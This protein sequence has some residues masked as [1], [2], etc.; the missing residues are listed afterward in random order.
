[1]ELKYFET[2]INEIEPF[3]REQGFRK[4]GDEPADDKL[5]VCFTG[6]KKVVSVIYHENTRLVKLLMCEISDDKDAV[7]FTEKSTWLFDTDHN[8]KDAVAIG[9]DFLDVIKDEMGL[10]EKP[11]RVASS[12]E[13][14]TKGTPGEAPNIQAFAAKFLAICPEF[15][16]VYKEHVEK[17]NDFLYV[18]F[19]SET[20]VPHLKKLLW[21]K[22]KKQLVK[23]FE[24]L[25]EMYATGDNAVGS[26]ITGVIIAEA[27][28]GD[29]VYYDECAGLYMEGCKY[30][31]QRGRSMTQGTKK[32]KV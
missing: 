25:D 17:Y 12:V 11:K 16:D 21:D 20:A 32:K 19:F 4:S 30:I 18:K 13:L 7:D 10:K 15:K 2:V 23:F 26:L 24:F 27:F 28:E 3:L 29:V 9:I 6:E 22:N 14:P 1:M 31:K 5:E 8:A